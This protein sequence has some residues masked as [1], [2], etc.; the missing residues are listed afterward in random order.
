MTTYEES[1][2]YVAQRRSKWRYFTSL[3]KIALTSTIFAS[4]V[5]LISY[6]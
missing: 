1:Y 4:V 5:V 2:E 6:I 3:F